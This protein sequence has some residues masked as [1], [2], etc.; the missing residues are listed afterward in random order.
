MKVN[1]EIPSTEKVVEFIYDL[2]GS[3]DES[4]LKQRGGSP[5]IFIDLEPELKKELFYAKEL[6]SELKEKLIEKIEEKMNSRKNEMNNFLSEVEEKW[7]EVERIFFSEMKRFFGFEDDKEF[8]C[9]TNNCVVSSYFDKKE[10]SLIYF[11][12]FNKELN[13][14][15]KKKLLSEATF[16][17][18]EEILHLLYF[19]YIRRIFGREF[20]F[21]EIYD[22]G[23]DNYSGWHL[24]ELMPEYLLVQNPLFEKFGWNKIN[25]EEQGYF[26]INE[27]RKKTD[28]IFKNKNF[29]DFIV[30]IH[31]PFF[32]KP[33]R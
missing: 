4:N 5:C 3:L 8:Y 10:V 16:T 14:N 11:E 19:D 28:P 26:W 33:K 17:V 7:R 29:K 32:L 15:K 27:I 21:D 12:E 20:S 30:E 6:T 1:F 9:Y 25:R 13:D 23:D 24:A 31:K 18:A 22:M 2:K